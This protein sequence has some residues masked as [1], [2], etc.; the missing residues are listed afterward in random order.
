MSS[1]EKVEIKCSSCG[2]IRLLTPKVARACTVGYLKKRNNCKSCGN[3][4]H[5]VG[6]KHG[7][8]GSGKLPAYYKVWASMKE[9][10]NNSKNKRFADYG[11]RGIVVCERWKDFG[12]FWEDMG[13]TYRSGLTLERKNVDGNYEKS[14]CRWATW[15][16]QANNT[17]TTKFYRF[18]GKNLNSRDWSKY[19]GIE[20]GIFTYYMRHY[21]T[22]GGFTRLL[23]RQKIY[24]SSN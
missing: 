4:I 11:G 22:P 21:G 12:N 2:K 8:V 3:L 15:E 18:E 5:G 7:H 10:C 19:F 17:R 6:V 14:N 13:N 1:N 9:R 20:K 16:E 23:E 24:V